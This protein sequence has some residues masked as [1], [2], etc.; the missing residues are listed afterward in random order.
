MPPRRPLVR[1]RRRPAGEE[2][3]DTTDMDDPSDEA[4]AG[5]VHDN[6][7]RANCYCYTDCTHADACTITAGRRAGSESRIRRRRPPSLSSSVHPRLRLVLPLLWIAAATLLLG[8]PPRMA[9]AMGG[10]GARATDGRTTPK[11][12]EGGTGQADRRSGAASGSASAAVV[13]CSVDGTVYTLDP[14][15]GN[16]RGI[17]ASGPALI[18]SSTDVSNNNSQDDGHPDNEDEDEDEEE[19][20][21]YDAN[22]H[23]D[24]YIHHQEEEND[25]HLFGEWDDE[26]DDPTSTTTSSPKQPRERIVPGLDGNLY[27][28]LPP[29][30]EDPS[31]GLRLERL[32]ISVADAV[33]SPISTCSQGGD[34]YATGTTGSSQPPNGGGGQQQQQ[35]RSLVMGEK[36]TKVFRL[37]PATGRVVWMQRPTGRRGGF[38]AADSGML[39]A[40]PKARGGGEESASSSSSTT[41]VLLQ[42]EDYLLRSVDADTGEERWNVTLGRFSALDFGS[43]SRGHG[44]SS[45]GA[46]SGSPSGSEG[47]AKTSPSD[48][49]GN[50]RRHQMPELPHRLPNLDSESSHI[51]DED[52]KSS[53]SFGQGEP[54]ML[55]AEPLPSVAFGDEGTTVIAISS[56]GK[57]LWQREL[58][59]VVAAVY[60]VEQNGPGGQAGGWSSLDVIEDFNIRSEAAEGTPLLESGG[61]KMMLPPPHAD[62]PP[63]E[64]LTSSSRFDDTTTD[65]ESLLPTMSPD[66]QE[67]PDRSRTSTALI[68]HG[69]GQGVS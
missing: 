59:S 17:F 5:Q 31:G 33:Q 27:S 28:L 6:V 13:I 25:N 49:T 16:L 46:G 42:R 62:L 18:S 68:P 45:A 48:G 51:D 40:P 39:P 61:E 30:P 32:P 15:S 1:P 44:H 10:G 50:D 23:D 64:R 8:Q 4:R 38:T 65:G 7:R 67:Q 63:I 34:G 41:S 53:R 43:S 66:T 58:D 55:G 19:E 56:S 9:H 52:A 47:A 35:Q 36:Q 60:G 20:E 54:Y 21:S 24:D 29:L 11:R 69:Y 37:D 2:V 12:T 22:T 14:W 3:P 57:I 26:E